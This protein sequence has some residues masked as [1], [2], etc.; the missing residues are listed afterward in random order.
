MALVEYERDGQ[1]VTITLNR[2]EKRNA[3]SNELRA[4]LFDAI[5]A[6]DDDEA[7]RDALKTILE[8]E[9]YDVASVGSSKEFL[10][11]LAAGDEPACILSDVRMPQMSGLDLLKTLGIKGLKMPIILITGRGYIDMAVSAIKLGAYDFIEK[12]FDESRLL[13]SI[14]TA[15]ETGRQKAR[16]AAKLEALQSRFALLSVRQRQ[17]MELAVAGFSNK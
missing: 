1:V 15:V 10:D 7:V 6:A 5:H 16:D 8:D 9:G 3:L 2:P 13:A 4:Q 12:P 14:R 11:G 17:V